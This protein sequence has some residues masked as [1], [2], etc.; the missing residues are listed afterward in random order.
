M[1]PKEINYDY[2]L[3]AFRRRF[4]YV[5]IPFFVIFM[6]AIV[7]CMKA[8]K[9]YRS[10]S[11]IL[12]QPQEVPADYVKSTVTS[13]V[14]SRINTITDEVLSRS[15][16]EQI[17]TKYG[18]YEKLR[19]SG[20]MFE[21]TRT[22][23]QS[24]KVNVK[25]AG[26]QWSRGPS[27]F[28]ISFEG[29][30]PAKVRDVTADLANLFLDRNYR[31]RAE[32]AAG[33]LKFL[34]REL[35]RMRETLRQK[36]E[37]VRQF[38]ERHLGSL[39]EQAENNSRIL[40]QLQQHMDSIN[41]SLQRA[42]DRKILLQTQ[43][44]RLRALQPGTSGS[45]GQAETPNTLEGLR[46]E[47]QRLQ[48]RYSD[49]HPDVVRIKR[50]IANAEKGGEARGGQRGVGEA[51]GSSRGTDTQRLIGVQREDLSTETQLI[52]KEILTLR[53]E[54]EKARLQ[55]EDY[56]Q[57]I[58]SGPKVE[59]MFV[60]LHRDYQQA[61]DNYQSL[62]QKKLQAQL[63][64]NLER[65]EKGEQFKIVDIADLPRVPYKPDI[66]KILPGGLV[67]ALGCGLGLAFL[68]EYVD[69]SFR[70][71]KE[72]EGVLGIPLLVTV[73]FIH[74]DKDLQKRKARLAGAVCLLCVMG[75]ALL[76]ALIILWKTT[77]GLIPS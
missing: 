24:I 19:S 17:I 57:R 56:R 37:L 58:E 6:A 64:E 13:D 15:A 39:P 41:A 72:V 3:A 25:Q 35:E 67:A 55:I 71:R 7:Y 43:S 1:I 42:E 60:D 62:L 66:R 65:T 45:A 44:S 8:P 53:Q 73:P 47:L 11:L 52:D 36:E 46:Q 74:T 27:S 70:S 68:L 59:Q 31:L 38:K 10:T 18:L 16:L 63:A 9:L 29:E 75:S 50:L 51:A 54:R 28:D 76:V 32:Q 23:R 2:L 26:D 4:W 77:S 14:R 30:S 49:K 12:V 48:S 5:V 33:T 22:L 40:T 69:R 61:S 34:D 20:R 21:A